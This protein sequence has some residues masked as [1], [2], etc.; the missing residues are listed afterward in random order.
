MSKQEQQEKPLKLSIAIAAGALVLSFAPQA[1]VA[2]PEEYRRGYHDCLAGRFDEDDDSRSYRSGCRDAREEHGD[3]ERPHHWRRDQGPPGPPPGPGGPP[4]F[5]GAGIP[6]VQGMD[7][8]GA[9]RV[10]ASRGYRNVGTSIAGGAIAGIYFNPQTRECFQVT[11][12]NGR[13]VD[14]RP[15]ADSRCR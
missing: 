12:V 4:H 13:V 11:T 7:P 2:G 9:L 10:L 6:N 5:A 15:S 14:T 3:D 8:I 1:A